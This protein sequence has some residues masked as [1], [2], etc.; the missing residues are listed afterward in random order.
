MGSFLA[1]WKEKENLEKVKEIISFLENNY[2]EAIDARLLAK[3]FGMST[4]SLTIAFK[5]LTDQTPREYLTWIRIEQAKFLLQETDIHIMFI[6]DRVGLDKSNLY[7]HFKKLT[8]LTPA[9]WRENALLNNNT[10]NKIR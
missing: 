6:A 1:Q 4:K 10:N 9:Q 7:I 3:K 2:H 5:A 8:G